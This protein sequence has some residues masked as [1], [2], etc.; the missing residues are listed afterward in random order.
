[1]QKWWVLIVAA[2][3]FFSVTTVDTETAEASGQ[4]VVSEALK[5]QG[6][7][8]QWGGKTPSGFD[9]S[10]FVAYAFAQEGIDLPF[11][12]ANQVHEGSR[13][14][15]SNLQP[16]DIVFFS[17][18]YRSG[19]SHNGI[20]IGNNQFV[21]TSA[22]QGVTVSSMNNSYWAPKYHSARRVA[23][24]S[25]SEAVASTADVSS[26]S[27]DKATVVNA[28]NLNVRSGPSLSNSRIDTIAGGTTVDVE[29]EYNY[30]AKVSD[31]STEGYVSLRFLDM[32][33]DGSTSTANVSSVS[34]SGQQAEVIN[35]SNVNVRSGG[36]MSNAVTGSI[37]G[38]STV[39]VQ[40]EFNY[41][42]K[43]SDGSTEGFVSLRFLDMK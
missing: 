7:P 2:F 28:T 29:E 32:D 18:T 4:G 42:A 37:S 11:G 1:M 3:M 43:V 30:W 24:S 16:G 17:G 22:S 26:S 27:S 14:S 23:D 20:Y 8:Y 25:S 38:G 36:S 41:W 13:V 10:G 34:S 40:E 9:C 21:H 12:T 39:E 5:H 31:G 33:N 15:R 19:V 35:T 6:T